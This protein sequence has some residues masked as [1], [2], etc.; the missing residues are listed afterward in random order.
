MTTADLY[1]RLLPLLQQAYEELGYPRK[2]FHTRLIQVVDHLLAAPE[3]QAMVAVQQVQVR[4]PIP[5]ERPWVR[6]EF[7][8]P[9][10]ESASAGHKLMVRIGAPNQHRLKAKLRQLRAELQRRAVP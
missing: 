10:L 8:D 3:P 7:V 2:R 6:Q 1:V 4:G 9:A 5:S